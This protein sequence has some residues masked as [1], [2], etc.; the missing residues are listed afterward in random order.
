MRLSRRS[1]LIGSVVVL[2]LV[3]QDSD[4]SALSLLVHKLQNA[5]RS[6]DVGAVTALWSDKSPQLTAQHEELQKLLQ[7][8]PGAE[9]HESA[10][11]PPTISADRARIR[12]ER[13]TSGNKKLLV[14]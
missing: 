12:V 10:S 3:A 11:K 14:L 8:G 1:V 7:A 4:P 5:Y 9:V 2:H 6:K 13:E